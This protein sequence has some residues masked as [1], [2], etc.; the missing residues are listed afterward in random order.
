MNSVTENIND[1]IS[2]NQVASV[3]FVDKNNK[4]YCI[5]CFYSWHSEQAILIFKSSFGTNHDNLVVSGACLSGTI[6]NDQISLSKIKGIQFNGDLIDQNQI[7]ELE[8]GNNY[9]KKF[10]LSIAMP[11]YLWGVKLNFIKFTDNTFVFG[12]KTN[13]SRN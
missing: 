8:L 1:F 9:L 13:W 4:P 12:N 10:P 7:N 3:C 2:E 6:L 11:G 5:N